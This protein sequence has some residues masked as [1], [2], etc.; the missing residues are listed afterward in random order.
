[1]RNYLIIHGSYSNSNEHWFPWLEEMLKNAGEEVINLDYPT[2]T[3]PVAAAEVQNYDAWAR[4]L[5]G[6]KDKI[7]EDTI[8]IGHS[9]SNIFFVKYCLENN[10]KIYR[11]IFVSGFYNYNSEYTDFVNGFV[12]MVGYDV[13]DKAMC[14]F[15]PENPEQFTKHAKSRI[16]FYSKNDPIVS[17]AK[18]KEFA[19][20]MDAE[21]ICIADAGHFCDG[22]YDKTFEEIIPYLDC[23]NIKNV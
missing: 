21:N 5:D 4:V 19:R 2:D 22:N 8:F 3:N 13:F 20:I 17:S 14:T 15:Y 9:I 16:C 23:A 18:L 11:A 10:I 1:M 7:N 12:G 6:V